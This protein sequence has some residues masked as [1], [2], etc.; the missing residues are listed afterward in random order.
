MKILALSGGTKNGNN[1]AICKE[2]LKGAQEQGAQIEFIRL[3]DLNLR[4]CTGCG[5]CM[6]SLNQGRGNMCSIKDDDFEWLMDKM[7]DA[8]GIVFSIPVFE[9]GAAGVFHT[10]LDRFGPRNDRGTNLLGTKI[11]RE[12]NGTLPDP[13]LLKEK[14]VAFMGM[15]GTDF[16]NRFVCDCSILS[17]TMMWTVVENTVFDWTKCFIMEPEKVEHAHRV[18]VE[19]AKAAK[20]LKQAKYIGDSGICPH[21]H[22]RNFY[23]NNNAKEAI[24]CTCGIHG[25]IKV[26]DGQIKF[27]FPDEQLQFA[28]DTFEGKVHHAQDIKNNQAI[29]V[30]MKTTEEFKKRQQA[31]V[32]FIS[33]TLPSRKEVL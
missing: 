24:C 26:V 8:D 22:S 19:L 28:Q 32:D 31:Y 15:G 27:V 2:A 11:A 6:R 14:A 12:K 3:L 10:L 23:L 29:R 25:E 17:A 16:V 30:Q 1:D 4:N 7:L 18:G 20:D 21:C 13:R 9:K 33:A 5:A